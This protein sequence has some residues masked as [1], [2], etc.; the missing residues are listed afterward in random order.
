MEGT[1]GLP[2]FG[3]KVLDVAENLEVGISI[4]NFALPLDV[5]QPV[6]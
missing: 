2:T 6:R 1:V 5:G 3:A 4:S